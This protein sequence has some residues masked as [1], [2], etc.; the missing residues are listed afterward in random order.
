LRL[1][2]G[3]G[4]KS[5]DRSNKFVEKKEKETETCER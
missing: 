4:E 1:K 2:G 5:K 3:G